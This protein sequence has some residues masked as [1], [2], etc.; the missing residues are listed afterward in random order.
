MNFT[1]QQFKINNF[2]KIALLYRGL[3]DNSDLSY[4]LIKRLF[5]DQYP[6]HQFKTFIHT[7]NLGNAHDGQ[8]YTYSITDDELNQHI[9]KYNTNN[10]IVDDLSRLTQ[11]I[12]HIHNI[13][14]EDELFLNWWRQYFA[15][16]QYDINDIFKVCSGIT[17]PNEDNM[18]HILHYLGQCYSACRSHE[19]YLD[20]E[21]DFKADLI[22]SLRPDF[23]IEINNM[24]YFD[25]I[26][27]SLNFINNQ[28]IDENWD[29]TII[30]TSTRCQDGLAW[31]DDYIFITDR[32]GARD[33]FGEHGADNKFI[34]L[35][36]NDKQ[37]IMN[38]A[39]TKYDFP[40]VWWPIMTTN[41]R[42]TGMIPYEVDIIRDHPESYE[43]L[44]HLST[45]C[46]IKLA[47][48]YGSLLGG[49]D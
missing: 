44:Q 4:L 41:S 2:M 32:M 39:M 47:Y 5:L 22:I 17:Q 23:W 37:R 13:N 26:E 30:S 25:I 48:K 10:V 29:N 12:E 18:D 16:K 27:D 21:H 40:H 1:C 28:R 9:N 3:I 36:I 14:T 19:L 15:N 31:T 34:D 46:L 7:W 43:N 24:E 8:S 11:L 35:F 38:A 20:Y 49:I 42:I 33:F 6:Q 45:E